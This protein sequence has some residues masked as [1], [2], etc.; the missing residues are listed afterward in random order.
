MTTGR[1]ALALTSYQLRCVLDASGIVPPP[2]RSRFLEA[3]QLISVPVVDDRAV[4]TAIAA[5]LARRGVC[6]P[7]HSCCCG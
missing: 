2:W 5:V 6:P 3:H 4:D 1:H 7:H